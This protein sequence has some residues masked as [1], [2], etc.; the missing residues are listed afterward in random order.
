MKG[1]NVVPWKIYWICIYVFC[2]FVFLLIGNIGI[3]PCI[4]HKHI[5]LYFEKWTGQP[6]D[7]WWS[8]QSVIPHIVYYSYIYFDY[9]A[10]K[11]KWIACIAELVSTVGSLCMQYWSRD[12]CFARSQEQK[13]LTTWLVLC[14]FSWSSLHTN[15]LVLRVWRSGRWLGL[16]LWM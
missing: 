12:T 1:Q 11:T 9:N 13:W 10:V 4:L 7:N 3:L 6:W 16:K 15:V 5:Y 8:S 2:L 14:T